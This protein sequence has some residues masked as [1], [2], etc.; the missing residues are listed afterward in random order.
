[1][2]GIIKEIT[3]WH[4][5]HFLMKCGFYVGGCWTG[6][7]WW[8]HFKLWRPFELFVLIKSYQDYYSIRVCCPKVMSAVHSNHGYADPL[9]SPLARNDL[10]SH[11][12]FTS[13]TGVLM[14]QIH[15][16]AHTPN[17]AFWHPF[18]KLCP[19]WL[20]PVSYTHLTLPTK[21]NV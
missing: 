14:I 2:Q 10:C 16:C 6:I 4:V 20:R 11:T 17:L 13:G 8:H 15:R 19:N 7:T 18:S 9:S 3:D 12:E 21:V 1:M 5:Q